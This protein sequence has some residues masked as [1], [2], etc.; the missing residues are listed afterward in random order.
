MEYALL[1]GV[2]V[3]LALMAAYGYARGVIKIVLTMVTTIVTLVVSAILT[4]PIS[5]IVE[6]TAFGDGIKSSVEEIV[7]EAE[8]VDPEQIYELEFPKAILEPIVEGANSVKED[9]Q[10]YVADAL[11]H[12]IIVALTFLVLVVIVYIIVRIV[13]SVIDLVSKLPILNG[14]NKSVGA[15]VGLLQGLLFVWIGCLILTACS[16]KAWAQEAFKQ[17]ND[18][19]LLSFIYNNNLVVWAISNIL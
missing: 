13:V 2:V 8:I 5:K 3:F 9:L 6:D 19:S 1:I 18:N 16:D 12:T 4:M 15:V 10:N 11:A 14:V 7:S 17:I